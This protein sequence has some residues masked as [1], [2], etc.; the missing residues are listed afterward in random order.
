MKIRPGTCSGGNELAP[1]PYAR[2][3]ILGMFVVMSPLET[4]NTVGIPIELGF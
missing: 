2:V 3:L 1:M 4:T